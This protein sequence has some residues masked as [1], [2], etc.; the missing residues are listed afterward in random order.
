MKKNLILL[1]VVFMCFTFLGCSVFSK[2]RKPLT[3]ENGVVLSDSF[4]EAL[5]YLEGF[6]TLYISLGVYAGK[7]YDS[8]QIDRDQFDTIRLYANKV[9]DEYEKS[10]VLILTWYDA[11]T[12]GILH[13][14][15][16]ETMEILDK[17][18]RTNLY[19]LIEVVEE[20]IPLSD[21]D[22]QTLDVSFI[23]LN[24]IVGLK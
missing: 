9:R 19:Q 18:L 7:A 11:E 13:N 21:E 10:K 3:A 6:K 8:G 23:L 15:Q 22:K 20:I 12:N 24:R 17:V 4:S 5:L 1:C 16:E 2:N 14:K